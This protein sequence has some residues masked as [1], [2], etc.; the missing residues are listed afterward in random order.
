MSLCVCGLGL[1]EVLCGCRWLAM[2]CE[3]RG[4]S[5]EVLSLPV[6]TVWHFV[7][8]TCLTCLVYTRLVQALAPEPGDCLLKG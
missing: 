4:G 3:H 2:G 5:F 1:S 8:P 6:L 7:V